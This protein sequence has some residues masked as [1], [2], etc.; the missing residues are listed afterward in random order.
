MRP[1]TKRKPWANTIVYFPFSTDAKDST[2]TY[3][4]TLN[5]WANIGT[6]DGVNCLNCSTSWAY[7][8]CTISTLPQWQQVRTNMARVRW[9]ALTTWEM[10]VRQY[11]SSGTYKAD[12]ALTV[13]KNIMWTQYGSWVYTQT[14]P[15]IWERIPI[16]VTV[17]GNTE[18]K[19]Y[20][21]WNLISTANVSVNT[22]WTQLLFAKTSRWNQRWQCYISNFI[23]E[24]KVRTASEISDYVYNTKNVYGLS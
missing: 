4:V 20:V 8:S 15:T 19:I 17:N 2:G 3:T 10:V 18:Q 11:W 1:D 7:G 13:S 12:C 24:N 21:M 9:D 6:I 22:N 5:W 16:A 14:Q 23:V